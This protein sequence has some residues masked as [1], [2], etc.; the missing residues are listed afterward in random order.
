MIKQIK[1]KSLPQIKKKRFQLGFIILDK[2]QS[3]F[4]DM[5]CVDR[6]TPVVLQPT[7][8]QLQYTMLICTSN[9][10]TYLE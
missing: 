4:K 2:T 6:C 1:H 7:E 8:L 5:V 10:K 9:E 3:G